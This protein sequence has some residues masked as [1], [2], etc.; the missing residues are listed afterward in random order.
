MLWAPLAALS[1]L[2]SSCN[3]IT[4]IEPVEPTCPPVCVSGTVLR[5]TCMAGTL[6]QLHNSQ[7]G[8][9]IQFDFDGTGV[10]TYQHVVS[11]YTELGALTQQGTKLYFNLTRGG[12]GPELQ[13]LANDAPS[14][15][16]KYTLSNV[17]ATA[18]AEKSP[19]APN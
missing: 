2:T 7:E 14:G 6:I 10:K 18:C 3:L 11:T 4:C 16:T 9:T 13:C 17:S 5:Q 1:L 19:A 12:T 15:M 8:Q